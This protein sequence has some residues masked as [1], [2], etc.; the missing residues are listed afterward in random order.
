MPSRR[1]GWKGWLAAL[2]ALAFLG[3]LAFGLTRDAR[4]LP[5]ALV[6]RPAPPFQG[7]TL[8][9]DTL[10]LA[11]LRGD[12]VILNFWASWCIP[13]REEHGV[14]RRAERRYGD[15]ARVV[16]VV[17]QDAPA[18]ARRFMDRLGGDWPSVLDAGSRIA[19]DYGVYGVPETFFI[20]PDGRVVK[21]QVGPVTWDVVR[22]TVDS[23]LSAAE[24]GTGTASSARGP[25]SSDPAV[26]EAG[27]GEPGPADGTGRRP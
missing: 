5:S 13:C 21:K 18:A 22:S 3:L 2:G 27:V 19:I 15:R 25:G 26:S 17:Y 8:E 1:S 9:G 23:L 20:G 24:A 4:T 12:V 7:E 14:L 16:G 6:G 11:S 10:S